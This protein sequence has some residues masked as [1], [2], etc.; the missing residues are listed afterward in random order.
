VLTR[1]DV[2]AHLKLAQA[3]ERLGK[4]FLAHQEREKGD[5]LLKKIQASVRDPRWRSV[6]RGAVRSDDRRS[7][8][9]SH[10]QP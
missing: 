9:A 8:D 2:D 4:R 3:Y 5:K 10:G 7:P 1:L 6:H